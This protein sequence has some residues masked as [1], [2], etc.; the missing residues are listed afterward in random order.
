MIARMWANALHD[1]AADAPA[2]SEDLAWDTC[3]L[4]GALAAVGR[5][6]AG[7]VDVECTAGCSVSPALA[8]SLFSIME[9]VRA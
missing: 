8:A 4:C 5:E 9:S 2:A 7:G 1:A 3:P 6:P